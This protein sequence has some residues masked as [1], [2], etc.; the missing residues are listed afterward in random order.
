MRDLIQP[1]PRDP[2]D[3]PGL[4]VSVTYLPAEKAVQVGGDWYHAQALPDGRVLLALG[5]VAGHGLE[6]AN[7][8]AHLR[9]SLIAW[10]SIG[11]DDPA[12]L[13]R[14]LNRLSSQL[15]ITGTAIIGVYDPLPRKLTWARAGHPVPILARAGNVSALDQH[16]GMLLGADNDAAYA[17]ATL[18]LQSGDLLLCYTD[19]LVDRRTTEIPT[20]LKQVRKVLSVVSA[21]PDE[22][23]LTQLRG[24]LDHPSPDDDTCTLA[25]RVLP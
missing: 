22:D 2:L 16:P 3:L 10:L 14:N 15:R 25:L 24:L 17:V 18:P 20:M 13:L 5:D 4:Q 12:T 6:A 9:F 11:I 23:T 1:V 19:G 21:R 7:G 8:M